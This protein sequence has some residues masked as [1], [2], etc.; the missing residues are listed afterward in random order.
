MTKENNFIKIV[1]TA[2]SHLGFDYP[3]RPRLDRRRRGHDFF[4]NYR[5]ILEHAKSI[6]A[7]MV[8]HG[9]DLF[10]RSR[11]H[12]K[13]VHMAYEPLLDA[14]DC[15]IPVY[16][17]PGNHERSKL[18]TTLALSH[19]NIFVFDRPKTYS[20]DIDG[21]TIALSGF[22]FRRGD[23]RGNFKAVLEQTGY[24]RNNADINMLCIHQAVEGA[25]VGPSNYTFRNS[26]D[27]IRLADIPF[28]F[29]AVLSGHIHRHQILK[30]RNAIRDKDLPVIYPGSIER[31]AFAEKDEDKGFIELTCD[32]SGVASIEFRKLYARPMVDLM[33]PCSDSIDALKTSIVATIP[34]F[35]ADAIV[36]IKTDRD[37]NGKMRSRLN[38]DFFRSI[39][40]ATMNFQFSGDGQIRK[41][42]RR[43]DRKVQI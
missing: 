38:T 16:L 10:F 7:D 37:M 25:T 27:T 2:D 30:K 17:V 6:Q 1:F 20:L 3:I 31:T 28:A 23:I 26:P 34:E 43:K 41:P 15:G 13:I 18:P 32:R 8:I 35:D 12:R 29:D 22:P 19:R 5:I 42:R 40:P 14:A 21:L 4:D 36:R 9:G 11:V 24:D 33:I 39:L